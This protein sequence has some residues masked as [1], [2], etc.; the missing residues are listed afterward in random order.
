GPGERRDQLVIHGT[1]EDVH[2]GVYGFGR[3]DTQAV[4]KAALDTPLGEEAC[5]LLAAAVDHDDGVP[6]PSGSGDLG[7]EAGPKVGLIEQRAPELYQDLQSRPS[8]SEKPSAR[9]IFWTACPAAPFIRLS[10]AL[11]TTAR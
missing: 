8:V 1:G 7:R 3:G 9:F 10:I 6:F 2:G 5:H 11:T 4:D